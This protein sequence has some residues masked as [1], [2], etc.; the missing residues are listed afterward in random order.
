MCL[1]DRPRTCI[2]TTVPFAQCIVGGLGINNAQLTGDCTLC[3]SRASYACM[4]ETYTK[5]RNKSR[6]Y[7]AFFEKM[8]NGHETI[9]IPSDFDVVL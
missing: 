3:F 5:P 4:Y 9:E 1:G 2:Q 7:T 6:A 8:K